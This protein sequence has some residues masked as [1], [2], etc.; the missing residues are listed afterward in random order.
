MSFYILHR[1]RVS[2]V[3]HLDLI[4]SLYSWWEGL[5]S[6][7]LATLLLG[8][9]CASGSSPGFV[10]EAALEDLVCPSEGQVWRWCSRYM[11]SAR[12]LLTRLKCIFIFVTFI[13]FCKEVMNL[14]SVIYTYLTISL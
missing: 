4:C 1:H 7:S 10:P 14:L 3:D 6:S 8:F 9:N 13:I 5:G 12:V 11:K 2:L